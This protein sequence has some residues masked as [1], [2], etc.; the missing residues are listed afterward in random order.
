LEME[1]VE[2]NEELFGQWW[3][4]TALNLIFSKEDSISEPPCCF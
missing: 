4:A 1:G 3:A 2:I